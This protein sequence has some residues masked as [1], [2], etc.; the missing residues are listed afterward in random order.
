MKLEKEKRAGGSKMTPLIRVS[1]EIFKQ[2]KD[3]AKKQDR[4]IKTQ[5]DRLL[6]AALAAVAGGELE[7]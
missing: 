2:V 7:P 5:A 6:T 3:L 1:Q 4:P